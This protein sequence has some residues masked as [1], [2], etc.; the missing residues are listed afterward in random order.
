MERTFSVTDKLPSDSIVYTSL[1]QSESFGMFDIFP[2]TQLDDMEVHICKYKNTNCFRKDPTCAILLK[3]M[4]HLSTSD[5]LKQIARVNKRFYRLSRDQD[6]IKQI[7]FKSLELNRIGTGTDTG[8][9][10]ENSK[11]LIKLIFTRSNSS[12]HIRKHCTGTL[13]SRF[14]GNSTLHL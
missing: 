3:I 5:I 9:N 12:G 4:G 10:P 2:A 6:L 1:S 8:E 7:K 11:L 14:S 13:P